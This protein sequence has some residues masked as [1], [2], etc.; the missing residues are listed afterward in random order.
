MGGIAGA[1]GICNS[2]P[3][4]PAN[5]GSYKAMLASG[6]IRRASVTPNSGDGQIDW[7]FRPNQAYVR[8]NGTLIMTTNSSGLFIFGTLN[9][10]VGHRLI[11]FGTG[12]QLDLG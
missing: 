3:A 2:D 9:T 4:K 1:D 6:T 12:R 7:V 5:S 8:L 10:S 11:L